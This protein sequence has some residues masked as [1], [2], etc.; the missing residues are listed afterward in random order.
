MGGILA[1]GFGAIAYIVFFLTFLYAIGFTSNLLVPK[2]IDT[3]PAGPTVTALLVN[4]G[5]LALFAVQ[6]SV[7]ARP[8]FKRAWTRIVPKSIE[9]S[10][11]VLL[12]SIVLILLFWQWRP[13]PSPVWTVT[14]SAAVTLLHAICALGWGTVLLSTFLINH[15]ELFGLSQVVARLRGRDTPAAEFRTPFLYRWMR[16][17]LYFGFLLAFWATPR[18]SA[19]S[20]SCTAATWEC[21]CRGA[22]GRPRH[23]GLP[24]APRRADASKQTCQ[25][26][27]HIV[28]RVD[29]SGRGA[30]R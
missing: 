6:H 12:A 24:R 19:S 14:D 20:I 21:C 15:F 1:L 9:R 11:Y 2:S 27:R 17:P 4:L 18:S 8:G 25:A 23:P 5:L 29:T 26:R 28:R 22:G 16:H 13:L 10:V 3:G 30:S 7:M